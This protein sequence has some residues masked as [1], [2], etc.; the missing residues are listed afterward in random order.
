ML[1]VVPESTVTTTL[2]Y[3]QEKQ[4]ERVQSALA[5]NHAMQE[6]RKHTALPPASQ[7]ASNEGVLQTS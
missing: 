5:Y 4:E 1:V 6:K 3:N 2:D 7:P